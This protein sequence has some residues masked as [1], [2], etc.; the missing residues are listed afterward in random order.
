MRLEKLDSP[1]WS[2]LGI[3]VLSLICRPLWPFVFGTKH[4]QQFMGHIALHTFA[5]TVIFFVAR[6]NRLA[7][8]IACAPAIIPV[9]RFLSQEL[10]EGGPKLPKL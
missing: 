1:A 7:T 3:V 2:V 8:C 5:I 6:G 10:D 4:R 9:L